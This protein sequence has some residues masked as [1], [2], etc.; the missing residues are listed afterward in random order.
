MFYIFN[1]TDPNYWHEKIT[2]SKQINGPATEIDCFNHCLHVKK[3]ECDFFVYDKGRLICH[4]GILS[5]TS[6]NQPTFVDESIT[7][8]ALKSNHFSQGPFNKYVAKKGWVI[9]QSNVYVGKI[10]RVKMGRKRLKILPR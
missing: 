2:F 6:G 4:I 10:D 7:L 9:H 3:D 8:F 5:V 1:E